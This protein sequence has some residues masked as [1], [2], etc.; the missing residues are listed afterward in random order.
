MIFTKWKS[1][2]EVVEGRLFSF[3]G[4]SAAAS[5][6]VQDVFW[7]YLAAAMTAPNSSTPGRTERMRSP[8]VVALGVTTPITIRKTETSISNSTILRLRS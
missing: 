4:C 5:P 3:A 1:R 2:P 7:R 8:Q 6:W